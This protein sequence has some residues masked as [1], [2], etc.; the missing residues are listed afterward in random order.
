MDK[1]AHI[2][3]LKSGDQE[4]FRLLVRQYQH[5]V[6]NTAWGFTHNRQDAEDIAQEVF[7]Y[8]FRSIKGFREK[9]SLSTWIYRI[10]VNKSLDFVKSSRRKK[11]QSELP[12]VDFQEELGFGGRGDN[13]EKTMIANEGL[14]Q[15]YAAIDAL[16]AKQKTA[17]VLSKQ[18]GLSNDEV[19]AILKT[20][21]S[22]VE[23]LIHRAKQQIRTEVK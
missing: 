1:P 22:A 17:I 4:A 16:P 5:K 14:K 23:A 15:I 7:L 11:R 6:V 10:T 9:S 8:I 20:S 12:D 3:L 18:E 21:R 19:A 2:T 13:P